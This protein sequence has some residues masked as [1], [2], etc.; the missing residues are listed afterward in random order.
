MSIVIILVPKIK[1]KKIFKQEK[2]RVELYIKNVFRYL[3]SN[4]IAHHVF[5]HGAINKIEKIMKI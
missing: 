2:I 4:F 5:N 1:I 3:I